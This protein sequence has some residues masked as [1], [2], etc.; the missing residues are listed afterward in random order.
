MGFSFMLNE[1]VRKEEEK[2]SYV[3]V[4]RLD[5]VILEVFSS[6]KNPMIPMSLPGSMGGLCLLTYCW[7]TRQMPTLCLTLDRS[8]PETN[9]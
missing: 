5:F 1:F 6:L 9:V 3:N 4:N 8:K 2:R 7:I